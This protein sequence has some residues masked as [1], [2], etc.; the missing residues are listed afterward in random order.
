MR[1]VVSITCTL[2]L[3]LSVF[4]LSIFAV[5]NAES[6]TDRDPG[7]AEPA[8]SA[9]N[10]KVSK[11]LTKSPQKAKQK[12][13]TRYWLKIN[14]KKNVCTAYEKNA[15][16]GEYIPIRAM[17]VSTGARVIAKGGPTPLGTFKIGWQGKWGELMGP[18]WGQYESHIVGDV[19]IHSVPYLVKGKKNTLMPGEYNRLGKSI[20]HGC[21]RMGVMDAKWVYNNCP[22]G[23]KVTVYRSNKS[24]P[25]GKPKL[26]KAN[27]SGWDPT[28]PS[29]GRKNY[30]VKKASISI[31]K[32]K[33]K[34]FEYGTAANLNTKVYARDT[35]VKQNITR[36]LSYST[37]KLSGKKYV[38]TAF[39]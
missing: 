8:Y 11:S 33:Q 1:K 2:A 31:S 10:A 25:L 12:D 19:L 21:V 36:Y 3:I 29:G 23:T 34:V 7:R 38:K 17:I 13:K 32:T 15:A 28:D 18:V 30:K 35:R 24:G 20:T 26:L 6:V 27:G 39:S 16:T 22:K 14:S 5:V 4:P 37:K 9:A